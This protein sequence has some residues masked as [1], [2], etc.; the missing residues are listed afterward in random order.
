MQDGTFIGCDTF[1]DTLQKDLGCRA[2]MD[3][4]YAEVDEFQ[5]IQ[6]QPIRE[7]SVP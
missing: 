2:K 6:A 3:A 4:K 7:E 5:R 1:L